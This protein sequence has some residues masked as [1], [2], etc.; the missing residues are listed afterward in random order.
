MTA[1]RVV[2]GR[3]IQVNRTIESFD[4]M[5]STP[6][7]HNAWQLQQGHSSLPQTTWSIA[8][9]PVLF[10]I[11]GCV[12]LL[13][14]VVKRGFGHAAAGGHG[15]IWPVFVALPVLGLF[16]LGGIRFQSIPRSSVNVYPAPSP[17][18]APSPPKIPQV[19]VPAQI[20]AARQQALAE[21][22]E[23]LNQKADS[24]NKQLAQRIDQMDIQEL[25][26]QFDAPRIVL[27]SPVA[28]TT[29][30]GAFIVI[31]APKIVA[32]AAESARSARLAAVAAVKEYSKLAATTA[33][34]QPE[35]P[36]AKSVGKAFSS[37]RA[38]AGK[39]QGK[40]TTTIA[41]I[42]KVENENDVKAELEF[43]LKPKN[44][45]PAWIDTP[46]K[47]TGDVRREVIATE[48]YAT[49]E[50]C[51]AAAYVYLLFKT[52]DHVRQLQNLPY[53]ESI[54]PS[55]SFQN[56]M[57]LADHQVIA[58]GRDHPQWMDSRIHYLQNLGIDIDYVRRE[59]VAKEPGSNEQREYLETVQRSV[60]PMKKLY[61]QVEFTPAF[62]R[63]VKQRAE[64]HR[65]TKAGSASLVPAPPWSSAC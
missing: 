17:P 16:L 38:S 5:A 18:Q 21:Q 53:Q 44:A 46:P 23:S 49:N 35:Q 39:G 7:T 13:A 45:R 55:I 6:Y 37:A 52:Y 4:P 42:V 36:P 47:R 58:T 34:A 41:K 50:E 43:N 30:P 28:P 59:I 3:E 54:L 62:D 48:E 1:N 26:D 11:V 22:V 63:E 40:P 14:L 57:I 20:S 8:L 15:R 19:I 29:N 61:L 31:A 56:G 32:T 10:I 27:E 64:S 25:M 60:G 24:A 2:P 65:A 33:E 9:A 51:Y 12:A